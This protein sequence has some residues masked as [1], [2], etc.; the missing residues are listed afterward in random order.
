MLQQNISKRLFYFIADL[1]SNTF[2]KISAV[3]I[4]QALAAHAYFIL[5]QV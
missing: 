5:S 3:A 2:Y 4:L 1:V